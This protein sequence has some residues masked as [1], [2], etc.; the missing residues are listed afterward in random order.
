MNLSLREI[1]LCEEWL[2]GNDNNDHTFVH[3]ITFKFLK[4]W[5]RFYCL[6]LFLFLFLFLFFFVFCFLF[7]FLVVII[8]H[9]M[10]VYSQVD[11]L[12]GKIET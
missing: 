1:C 5:V 4:G 10:I 12:T 9:F 3:I 8:R 2:I 11:S 6:I 7:L